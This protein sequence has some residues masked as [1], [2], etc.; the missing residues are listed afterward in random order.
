MKKLLT[1]LTM[2]MIAI[3][4]NAQAVIAEVDWTQKSEWDLNWY[5]DEATV[6]VNQG[7]GLI[8]DCNSPSAGANY[9]EPQVPIIGHIPKLDEGG[10]YQVKFQFTSPVAGELRLDL[11]SWDGSGATMATVFEI[12]EG[13]NDL[14]IDFLDYPTPCTDAGIM[15]QCGKLPGRHIIKNVQVI[16]L[17]AEAGENWTIA[18]DKNL[19]GADWDASN[20][21]NRMYSL[22]GENY[23]LN[24]T[25]LTLSHG[26]YQYKVFKDNLTQESYPSS[27]ASLIINEDGVYNVYF[28]F[29]TSTKELTATATK[30]EVWTI[31]GDKSLLGSDWDATDKANKMIING[32]NYILTKTNLTLPKGTYQYKV[33]KDYATSESYP[34][35]NASLVID[36][37]ATYTIIFTFNSKTKEL[38]ATATKTDGLFFNYIPKG[39]VA[40]LIQNPNKYKGTVIIPSSVTHDGQEYTVTKI[41][42]NAFSNSNVTSVTIPN[43]VTSIGNGAFYECRSL[44][45]VSIP[46]SVTSIGYSAF[47]GCS[48]LSSIAIPNSVTSIGDN[49]FSSCTSL[50]SVTIPNSVTSIGNYAFSGCT[51]LTSVTIPNS[52]TS[53]GS[54][55][56]ANCIGLT[57][58]IIP[59]SVT[60][61]SNNAFSGCNGL[62]SVI[63]PNSV[64]SIDSYVFSGCR[65]LTSVTIPNSVTSIGNNAF[66]GC[67]RLISVTIGESANWISSYAFG[68]C[69]QLSDVYC[70]AEYI[71]STATNAFMDSYI[72]YATLH[73]PATS[74][75]SYSN[76]EPWKN[77]KNKVA[78]SGEDIPEMPKCA[79]PT[80]TYNNGVITFSCET[81][82]VEFISEVK[83]ND[84]KKEY[85]NKIILSNTYTVSV[86]ATKAGYDNSETVTMEVIGTGGILGDL[87]GDGKVDVADHVKLSNIIMNK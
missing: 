2:A 70:L 56:F 36:E 16:D 53:I 46:N 13:E 7:E 9:W 18:G 6:T 81:E 66:S 10:H 74:L 78:L 71:P 44:T 41:G 45:S 67:S 48:Q 29:N 19:L 51:G 47:S 8:I 80:I 37:D 32:A 4:A 21:N 3:S 35:S 43:S 76:N 73:V 31:A 39:K 33:F 1:L 59:N 22:D 64:T 27:N 58:V 84:N 72:E 77:F 30:I 79:T 38:S 14:T 86:Y 15:Y 68:N 42:D 20:T 60:S 52:V 75:S 5:A 85:N 23:T 50:T 40:E 69:K 54:S 61:I 62:T 26:T 34:S 17:E 55:T 87:T 83:A 24:K 82:G 63:I 28:T 57:S 25:G 12:A 49:T 65:G 11:Y